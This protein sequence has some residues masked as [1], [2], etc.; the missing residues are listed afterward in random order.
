MI[1]PKTILALIPAR[2]GSKRVSNKNLRLMGGK[3]LIAWTI[4]EAQKSRYIDRLILS[5]EDQEILA[6]ARE[7]GCETPFV[8]PVELAQDHSSGVDPVLHALEVLPEKFDYVLLLQPTSPLRLASDI[9]GCLEKCCPQ[10]IPSCISVSEFIKNP[11]WLY[12]INAS[13]HLRPFFEKPE[14]LKEPKSY[15]LNGA[16]YLAK[17][18]WLQQQR[19]FHT[20]ESIAYVMPPERSLDIDTEFE[21]FLGDLILS[22]KID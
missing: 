13:Q 5:S 18:D 8:R 9:D 19:T 12:T 10:D 7:W 14:D 6:V 11:F 1:G 3:P 21:F 2:G 15:M 17:T 20:R 16:L 22:R 4:V